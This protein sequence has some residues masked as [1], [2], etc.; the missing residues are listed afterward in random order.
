[1]PDHDLPDRLVV[2]FDGLCEP[3]PYGWSTYGWCILDADTGAEIAC[4]EGVAARE[5]EPNSTNNYAEYC[6]LGFALR[7]LADRGWQGELE[8]RGDSQLVIRQV[9]GAW[10]CN[11]EHLRKLRDRCR[12]MLAR[13]G[14]GHTLVWVPREENTRCDGLSKEAYRRATGRACP[15]R[16]GRK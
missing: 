6:A 1:M 16:R 3:N 12:D 2:F 4:D 5:G 9:G 10:A 11:K 8:V 15:E 14:G 7:F 13:L